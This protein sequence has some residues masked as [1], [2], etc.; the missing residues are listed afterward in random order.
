MNGDTNSESPEAKKV[1]V[2]EKANEASQEY[3]QKAVASEKTFSEKVASLFNMDTAAKAALLEVLDL[4]SI[5]T[6]YSLADIYVA[7]EGILDIIKA[8]QDKDLQRGLRGILKLGIAALPEVPVAGLAPIF[9]KLLPD[10]E[11]EA[12]DNTNNTTNNKQ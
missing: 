9:D 2:E 6:V 10:K 12:V 4:Q 11:S 3:Q 1:R 8:V 5:V 7:G